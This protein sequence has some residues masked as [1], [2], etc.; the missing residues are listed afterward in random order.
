MVRDSPKSPVQWLD[1]ILEDTPP[2]N[3]QLAYGGGAKGV[4]CFAEV[5]RSIK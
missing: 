5:S 3:G 1:R 4:S 2:L